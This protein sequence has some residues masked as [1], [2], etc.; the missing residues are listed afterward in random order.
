M[1]LFDKIVHWSGIVVHSVLGFFQ[2]AETAVDNLAP[3]I[4]EALETGAS[5]A[6]LIPGVGPTAASIL[7]LGVEL[8]GAADKVLH[9]SD[10]AFQKMVAD[11]K[12]QLPADSGYSLVL[13]PEKLEGDL[14]T[15]LTQIKA[16]MDKAK[17]AANAITGP[18]GAPAAKK[19]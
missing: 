19:A 9:Y 14:K 2:K 4:E 8:V 16:E 6:A 18:N 5:I 17:D 13:I 15:F 12:A 3:K 11:A 1:N 7:N 10:E